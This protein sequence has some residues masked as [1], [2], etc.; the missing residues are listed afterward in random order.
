MS[1]TT[2]HKDL[3]DWVDQWASIL[4]PAA[5]EWC[6]GSVEEYDRLCAALVDGGHVHEARR[7]APEQLLGALRSG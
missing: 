3:R 1:A 5:I 2:T 4:Q 7:S 6:D